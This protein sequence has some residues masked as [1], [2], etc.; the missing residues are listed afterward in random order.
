VAYILQPLHAG[1]Q[2]ELAQQDPIGCNVDGDDHTI[3]L[4][5]SLV[6]HVI[7]ILDLQ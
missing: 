7:V 1:Y 2:A 3:R 6:A 5:L 4:E